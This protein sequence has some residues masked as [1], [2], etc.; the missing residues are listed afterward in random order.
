MHMFTIIKLLATQAV[1]I[2]LVMLYFTWMH[3]YPRTFCN[4][5]DKIY[6]MLENKEKWE[7]HKVPA[8]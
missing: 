1:L 3:E 5:W 6:Y 4:F 8:S 7:N 2:G